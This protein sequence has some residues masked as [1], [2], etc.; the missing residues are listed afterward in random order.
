MISLFS[1]FLLF[2]VCLKCF[3]V[4]GLLLHVHVY[5]AIIRCEATPS[6]SCHQLLF[7]VYVSLAAK[8][9][10]VSTV[11]GSWFK[12]KTDTR[13]PKVHEG[14]DTPADERTVIVLMV[15]T[16]YEHQGIIG[17]ECVA[18]CTCQPTR[19]DAHTTDKY[20]IMKPHAFAVTEH[21][22]CEF[23]VTVL[24]ETSSG[25]H[26]VRVS[27]MLVTEYDMRM[28]GFHMGF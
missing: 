14:K 28:E 1:L 25:Q 16:S 22:Q 20:S 24:P 6:H 17:I 5:D 13:A 11:V 15:L 7:N 26:K 2:G 3:F 19:F 10:W 4:C 23:K 27:G 21:E 9:G 8:W 18:G 12:V